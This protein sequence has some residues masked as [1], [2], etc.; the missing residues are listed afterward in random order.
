MRYGPPDV[1]IEAWPLCINLF[2]R[3]PEL[4]T[5]LPRSVLWPQPSCYFCGKSNWI[6]KVSPDL[7]WKSEKNLVISMALRHLVPKFTWPDVLSSCLENLKLVQT[8]FHWFTCLKGIHKFRYLPCL[9]PQYNAY[10]KLFC[11]LLMHIYI[12][13]AI[14]PTCVHQMYGLSV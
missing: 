5:S 4:I 3:I 6:G 1:S 2:F 11:W 13:I 14:S 9:L 8:L 10:T 7:Q 12:S